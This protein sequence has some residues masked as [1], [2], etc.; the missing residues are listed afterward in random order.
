MGDTVTTLQ[1]LMAEKFSP[2]V[3]RSYHN[4]QILLMMLGKVTADEIN[5]RGGK[6]PIQTLRQG[7][8]QGGSESQSMPTAVN[9]E[10]KDWVP[11]LK[12]IYS[13]GEFSGFAHWQT[14][15]LT[16]EGQANKLKIGGML[17]EKIKSHTDE[18]GYFL[19]QT[20][21]RD[22]KGK[23]ADAIAARTTGV[24]GT[25]TVTPSTANWPVDEIPIGARVNFYTSAGT[26]HNATKAVST[27]TAVNPTTGVVTFDEVASDCAVG[28]F[29]VWEGSWD[30]LPNGLA[31]LVQN[32]SI[33][34]QGVDVTNYPK[35]KGNVYSASAALDIRFVNRL[36]TRAR[37]IMGTKQPRN[38]YLVV[39]HPKEVDAYR[40]AGYALNTVIDGANRNNNTL[41]LGY[42]KVQISGMDIYESNGCGER[43]L[44]GLRLSA[45]KRFTVFEPGLLPL[46][47]GESQYL[48][49]VPGTNTYKH[50]YQ[51]YMAFY[52]NVL[53]LTPASHFL[54]DAL[55]KTNLG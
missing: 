31:G 13:T 20:F 29:M 16:A 24:G 40:N 23:L 34:F 51:Y 2:I 41:D 8:F 10:Y 15:I 18:F 37:Q 7:S 4:E 14:N 50:Q 42:S 44:Y 33:T 53:N 46:G 27:V 6:Y 5:Q 55:D 11:A 12:A 9:G 26:I 39:T 49:P 28:D 47:D 36:Q 32:Q 52:G 1:T 22:G 38:D 35:L 43:Q 25:V 17:G 54:V 3:S 30:L 45:L 48:V 21:F 19:D